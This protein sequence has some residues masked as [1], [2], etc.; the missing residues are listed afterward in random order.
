MRIKLDQPEW[1]RVIKA[2]KIK[3]PLI[4][5]Q[6]AYNVIA[7][8]AA[9]ARQNEQETAHD[10]ILGAYQHTVRRRKSGEIEVIDR[11]NL[12]KTN[13]GWVSTTRTSSK[14]GAFQM[15]HFSWERARTK[16]VKVAD[17]TNQLAN[18]W[19][20]PTKPYRADSPEVGRGTYPDNWISWRAGG[21]RP[22]RYDWSAVGQSIKNAI[23]P[24]VAKTEKRFDKLLK[25]I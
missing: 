18:L 2:L 1:Q 11:T 6:M 10:L 5:D 4:I 12:K 20:R 15:S 17:Y 22:A 8:T 23:V 13:A 16:H 14:T 24:A 21:R 9:E 7:N 19:H 25:E 3:V